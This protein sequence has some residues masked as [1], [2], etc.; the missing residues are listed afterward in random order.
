MITVLFF[1]YLVYLKRHEIISILIPVKIA[2]VIKSELDN[3]LEIPLNSRRQIVDQCKFKPNKYN[4]K[5]KRG[6]GK[7]TKI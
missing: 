4:W 1:S 2:T 7:R 6:D 3:F 5:R